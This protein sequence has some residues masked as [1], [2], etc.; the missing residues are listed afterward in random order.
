[1]RYS[2]FLTA[3]LGIV[4]FVAKQY[5]NAAWVHPYWTYLLL[6][7]VAI[8]ALLHRL[9][10]FVK[11]PKSAQFTSFY[12]TFITAKLVLSLLFMGVLLYYG[13]PDR[14]TFVITFLVLYLVYTS[15]EI[16]ALARKL[17]RDS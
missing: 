15:F 11:D 3:L 13:V 4:F 2:L 8:S 7:Y 6:F 1:M 9:M 10:S 5:F 16:Y 12:M 17:R 14:Q